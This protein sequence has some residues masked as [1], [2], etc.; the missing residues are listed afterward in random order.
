MPVLAWRNDAD[1]FAFRNSWTFDMAERRALTAMASA[2]TPA[3]I[4]AVVAFLPP[5]PILLTAMSV[6]AQA[7]T[8]FGPLSTYGLCGGMAYSSL[9]HWHA[10]VP[11]PRGAHVDDQPQRTAPTPTV[12]RDM[13]WARLL[14]SLRSGGVLQRTIEWSLWLNQVPPFLGGG[15]AWL[16]RATEQE[17]GTVKSH[18]DAGQPWPIGLIYTMTDIW[19]QHQVLA[20]GYVDNGNRTGSLFV[21]DSIAPHQFGNTGHSSVITLDFT[22]SS[23]VAISPSDTTGSTLAG[24]FCSNYAPATPPSGLATQYGQFLSWSGDSRTFMT[25]SGVRLPVAG[26]TELQALGATSADVRSTMATFAPTSARPRDNSLLRERSAAPVFL[27][28]GGAPFWIPDPN[29]LARFGDWNAVRVVPDGT[30]AVFSAI[31]DTGTLLREWSDAKVYRVENGQ[32]RWVT[33]PTELSRWGGF[34]SVR[35]VPDGALTPIP[36]GPVLPSPSPNECSTLRTRITQ[37]QRR[38]A[39]L[40]QQ[41]DLDPEHEARY[42]IQ[43]ARARASLAE[44]EARASAIGCP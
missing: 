6:A 18:I 30:L 11:I 3:A 36:L 42:E 15:G 22:G 37:L 40:Q 35:V 9:D 21:Y 19:N 1:G 25:T 38:I 7:Y 8:T 12:I 39:D 4:A 16:N 23:L 2:V 31:P 14:D 24:F 33:T 43:L 10:N 44:S 13:L 29:W 41:Q 32:R 5:D 27:Y 34:P 17:W 26:T 28:E 20:Y